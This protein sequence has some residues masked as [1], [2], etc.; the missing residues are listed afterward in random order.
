MS[1]M[2]LSVSLNSYDDKASSNSPSLN[3]F[4]W[5]RDA[6]GLE[7]SNPQSQSFKLAPGESRTM[8][9][10]TRT[11]L[12]D[13][14]TQLQLSLKAGT[15]NTYVVKH[16]GGTAPQF[17]TPRSTG[18]DATTEVTVTQNG[19]VLTFTSTAGTL[20]SLGAVAVGD[21]VKIGT[22]FAMSNQGSFKVIA[23]TATSFSVENAGGATEGPI[24]LGAS[25]ADEVRIFSAAGVQVGDT[26]RIF[27]GFS[28]A[29]Q[30]SYEVTDVSDD[31]LEFY[32]T[33]A[34]PQET[35]TTDQIAV[36]TQAKRIVYVESSKKLSISINGSSQGSLEPITGIES[37]PA[38]LLKTEIA[39]SMSM[40]NDSLD[41]ADV[42]FA[43]VE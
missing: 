30:G 23:K 1:K 13:G 17:R 11:L 42:F 25:F 27:G 22:V 32:S 19:S 7:V 36:Y 5:F 9:N 10:G 35:I 26:L 31:S 3:L 33:K 14:T 24:T 41:V 20:F 21:Q 16:V 43:S 2:N 38:M 6:Q 34:L 40:T 4:K 15:S 28:P 37:K 29:S 8:F 12:S 39:W 18:A